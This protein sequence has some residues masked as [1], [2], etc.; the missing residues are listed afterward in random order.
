[1]SHLNKANFQVAKP[2]FLSSNSICLSSLRKQMTAERQEHKQ[3]LKLK[4]QGH[5]EPRGLAPSL[6]NCLDMQHSEIV[7]RPNTFQNYRPVTQNAFPSLRKPQRF[8]KDV[9]GQTMSWSLTISESYLNTGIH[10]HRTWGLGINPGL[11]GSGG[12]HQGWCQGL[13]MVHSCRPPEWTAM[14]RA[15]ILHSTAS[16]YAH[17]TQGTAPEERVEDRNLNKSQQVFGNV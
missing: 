9:W 14:D 2:N 15:G 4:P 13:D 6:R 3:W 17:D 16:G 5:K 7:T 1:M 11:T 12:D 8:K 10:P